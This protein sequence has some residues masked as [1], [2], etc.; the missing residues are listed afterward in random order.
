VKPCVP[1][2]VNSVPEKCLT[3]MLD[4]FG[5]SL[6]TEWSLYNEAFGDD[7]L[8]FASHEESYM[9]QGSD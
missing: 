1:V 8:R 9:V 6:T 3:D 4:N 7:A 2:E 5:G